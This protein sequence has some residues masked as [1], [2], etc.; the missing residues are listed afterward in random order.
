MPL[1]RLTAVSL[2]ALAAFS[3]AL[4]AHTA[5]AETREVRIAQQFGIGYLP[6]IVVRNQ[7]L[8]EKHVVSAGLPPVKVTWARLS[9]GAATNDALLSGSI[10]YV[11]AGIAPLLILW[12]KTRGNL[13]V[14]GVGGLDASAAFINTNNPNVKTLKDF[15]EKDR[16][17]LPAVKV[18]VQ[19]I[20]LQIAAEKAF[21]PGQHFK[22]DT[23]TVGLPHPDA[24]AALLSGSSEITAHFATAPFNFQQLENPKVHRVLST[25]ELFDGPASL[26]ALYAIGKFRIENPKTHRAVFD[27]FSEANAFIQRDPAAAA[28]IFVEEEKSNL[29]EQYL[30][31]LLRD[32][33]VKLSWT[34]LN[35]Q[36]IADYLHRVGT[37][38]NKPA[39]WQDYFF[40]EIHSQPGS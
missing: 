28:R 20:L 4:P 7:K 24:T 19:A 14:R 18:S 22:L 2:A 1:R 35:T 39:S 30:E 17:A 32:P 9:G 37:I 5:R 15:T 16:I 6:L 13:D 27:A 3:L 10:D 21:G 8:I 31:K 38:K 26:N 12:D 33:Q 23:L 11:A 40:P 34:P 36:K 29:G 25:Y